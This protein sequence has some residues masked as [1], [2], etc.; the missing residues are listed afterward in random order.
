[1]VLAMKITIVCVVLLFSSAY[2]DKETKCEE[3]MLHNKPHTNH[4]LSKGLN[5]PHQLAFDKHNQRLFFSHNVRRHDEE[6]FEIGYIEKDK[7]IPTIVQSVKNGYAIAMDNKDAIVYYGGSNGIYKQHLKEEND[8]VHEVVKVYNVWN[9]FFKN[10]LYFIKYSLQQL[11]KLDEKNKTAE[12]QKYI[13]EKIYHFAIDGH[14]DM[15]ITTDTGLFMIKNGTQERI[16]FTGPKNFLAI[17]INNEGVAYFGHNDG[18]YTANKSDHTLNIVANIKH[19]FGI[20]FDSDDHIIYSDYHKIVKL[21]P[22]KC[23]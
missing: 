16:A 9:M 18:I 11:Y 6:A 10:A 5:R 19:V 21:L 3:V 2:S 8:T 22:G 14:N 12:H 1:M 20:T 13:H 7:M 4:V 23:K 17:A 15:F